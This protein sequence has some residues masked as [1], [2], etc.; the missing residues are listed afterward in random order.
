[1]SRAI[2]IGA[3]LAGVTTAYELA[4]RGFETTLV[5]RR[6]DVALETSFANGAVLTPSMADPWNGPGVLRQLLASFCNPHSAMKLRLSALPSLGSWG[7]RFIR[8][9]SSSRHE[10]ATKASFQLAS[11]SLRQLETLA[12]RLALEYD[13]ASVGTVKVFRN[14]GAM[15]QPLML[16][17]M[18]APLGLNY[19]VLSAAQTVNIEPALHDI[20]DRIAGAIRYPDDRSGDAREFCRKLA[21]AFR[22]EGGTTRFNVTVSGIAH[23]AGRVCG[24]QLEDTLEP[25]DCVVIA[26]GNESVRLAR[27]LGISLPIRPAKGYSLTFDVSHVSQRPRV[28]IVDDVLHAGVVP[29]G[30]RLRV[31]GTAEFAGTDLRIRQERVKNLRHLL[32]A[33][34]PRI[35]TELAPTGGIAWTGLRP[36]SADG[37]PFIG[38]TRIK[39]LHV[40]AGHGH[41]GWTLAA[42]SASLLADLMEGRTPEIDAAPYRLER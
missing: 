35:A 23:R 25:A 40:N 9:S 10:A 38:A 15:E 13:A 37:L 16:A 30:A 12:T 2:V 39:G 8:Y 32:E 4:R 27:P 29:I 41:L 36:M 14:A 19:E 3:G 11:Y 5:E 22:R 42:G 34:Y 17:R 7:I 6:A 28:P 18:L 31:V 1:M 21:A 20:R 24:V 26:A 33:I